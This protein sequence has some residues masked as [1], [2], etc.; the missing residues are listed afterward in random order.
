MAFPVRL[1]LLAILIEASACASGSGS[2]PAGPPA[3]STDSVPA[4]QPASPASSTSIELPPSPADTDDVY[5]GWKLFHIHCFRCHGFDAEGGGAPNL[6]ESVRLRLTRQAFVTTVIGGRPLRGMPSWVEVLSP[7]Q[8]EL[9][10]LYIV[11]RATGRLG[12]GTPPRRS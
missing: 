12:T 4:P 8:A 6:R 1:V 9:I 2:I 3:P 10:Y 11:E 5:Q 7:A